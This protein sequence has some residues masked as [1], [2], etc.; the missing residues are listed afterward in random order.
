M[1]CSRGVVFPIRVTIIR[2]R[3]KVIVLRISLEREGPRPGEQPSEPGTH[4][5]TPRAS[6]PCRDDKPPDRTVFLHGGLRQA[7]GFLPLCVKCTRYRSRAAPASRWRSLGRG[8]PL[9]SALIELM[10]VGDLEKLAR[11]GLRVGI[12]AR[13]NKF[14]HHPVPSSAG[15][16][17]MEIASRRASSLRRFNRVEARRRNR[18]ST[19]G[20][21]LP[22]A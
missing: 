4:L 9:Y 16:R 7:N 6:M 1:K 14:V 15:N 10:S 22:C 13:F 20:S 18:R 2:L 19:R 21:Y 5:G 3:E 11:R 12:G 17:L 8:R